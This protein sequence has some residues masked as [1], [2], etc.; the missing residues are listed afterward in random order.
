MCGSDWCW[1]QQQVSPGQCLGS[2]FVLSW[3]IWMQMPQADCPAKLLRQGLSLNCLPPVWWVLLGQSVWCTTLL[4]PVLEA[5]EVVFQYSRCGILLQE[6]PEWLLFF[7]EVGDECCEA[8]HHTKE[9]LQI[10]FVLWSRH[11]QDIIDHSQVWP[12]SIFGV[13]VAEEADHW[14]RVV[15]PV[16][17]GRGCTG[18]VGWRC[19]T[20]NQNWSRCP[21][22][23]GLLPIAEILGKC[24]TKVARIL[25]WGRTCSTLKWWESW[26]HATCGSPCSSLMRSTDNG[27][28][29]KTSLG[30]PTPHTWALSCCGTV[31]HSWHHSR[32]R[33]QQGATPTAATPSGHQGR[34]YAFSSTVGPVTTALVA[35]TN[36]CVPPVA[37]AVMQAVTIRPCHLHQLW[38]RPSIRAAMPRIRC[39]RQ[40]APR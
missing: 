33:R 8:C 3:E 37:A 32:R 16:C 18:G 12:D 38:W 11:V 24:L 10:L 21:Q 34:N 25:M 4:R 17:W 27:R 26:R 28:L 31:G 2:C 19:S 30:G 36:T 9:S 13:Y 15:I 20:P 22:P 39:S 7:T 14:L 29:S 6:I 5:V 23:C 40:V 1:I 35:S